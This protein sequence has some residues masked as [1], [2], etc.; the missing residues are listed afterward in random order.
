MAA[1]LVLG[2]LLGMRHATDPDH[3]VAMTTII[4]RQPGKRSAIALGAAWGV[5][6]TATILL[7]GGAIIL[8]GAVIPPRVGLSL[9]MAVA[10][11]L[12]LLGVFNLVGRSRI[13]PRDHAHGAGRGGLGRGFFIGVIHGLAG[14]AAVALLVLSTIRNHA[15]ALVYL[16]IFGAGTVLGMM[17]LTAAMMASLAAVS[18][19]S[20][21]IDRVMTGL[22]GVASIAFGLFLS[23]RL[24]LVDGLFSDLPRWTP[25]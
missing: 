14:S 19:H 2:L 12:I 3:V 25:H 16:A 15:W 11:M 10:V 1:L 8:C 7:F 18:R 20:R 23:Y 17:T 13:Q 22:S 6:H 5:G 9:E 21:A 24:T 4:S